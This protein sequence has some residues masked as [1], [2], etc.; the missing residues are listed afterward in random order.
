LKI[1]AQL[2]GVVVVLHTRTVVGRDGVTIRDVACRDMS[3]REEAPEQATAYT[4]VFVRRG[5]FVRTADGMESVCDP[6]V[7][8]CTSPGDVESF[9]HPHATGDDCT[10]VSFDP[11]VAIS[12]WGEERVRGAIPTPPDFD[13]AHRILLAASGRAVDPHEMVESAMTLVARALELTGHRAVTAGRPATVRARATVVNHAR[14]ALAADPDLSLSE[15]ARAVAVSPHH[16]SRI[17]RRATGRTISRH[18]MRLRTRAVLE[19]FVDGER[20][21]ARLAADAG[22]ADQSHLCRVMQAETGSAPSALRALLTRER[23]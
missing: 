6:T 21:L 4:V 2:A 22:F 5:C 11:S 16:L 19:R 14:Q 1:R 13:L 9:D 20:D 23:S 3:G 18:R 8:Y 17:F 10:A 12:L 15:L 7:A